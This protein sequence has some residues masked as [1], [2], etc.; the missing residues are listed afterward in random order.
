[1]SSLWLSVHALG[2]AVA[3]AAST[4]QDPPA[5]PAQPPAA[6]APARAA[7]KASTK[8][9]MDLRVTPVVSF[10]PSRVRAIAELKLPADRFPDFYCATV[11]WDWGD[12]TESSESN[13]CDPYESGVSDVRTRFSAEHTYQTGGRYRVQIR[14][15]RNRK[16]LHS[17]STIVTVRPGLRDQAPFAAEP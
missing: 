2:V 17:T 6:P 16:V 3:V 12:L 9:S 5:A 7:D 13:E 15:R 10:A 14:L 4:T 1:M 11:E 8:L